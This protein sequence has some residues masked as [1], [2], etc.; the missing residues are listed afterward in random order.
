MEQYYILFNVGSLDL[1]DKEAL[2]NMTISAAFTFNLWHRNITA[3]TTTF[4]NIYVLAFPQNI[5]LPYALVLL[6]T[7]VC[8][9][10]GF[11]SLAQNGVSAA[12][13]SFLQI[14]TT[15][16]GDSRLRELAEGSCLGDGRIFRKN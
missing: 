12:D 4:P 11:Y 5:K 16:T 3:I 10:I 14:L 2:L 7:S 6:T 8:I 13:N 1:Y 9:C 15:T